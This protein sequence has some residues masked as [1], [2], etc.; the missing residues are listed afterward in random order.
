MGVGIASI[1]VFGLLEARQ[2][3][4]GAVRTSHVGRITINQLFPRGAVS[5]FAMAIQSLFLA[6]GRVR[7]NLGIRIKILSPLPSPPGFDSYYLEK[8]QKRNTRE[9]RAP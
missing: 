1:V 6:I 9:L 3:E 8:D 4:H 5:L 2:V 7:F